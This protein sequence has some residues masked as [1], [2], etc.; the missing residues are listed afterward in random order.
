M[1]AIVAVLAVLFTCAI[2]YAGYRV[3]RKPRIIA[4]IKRVDSLHPVPRKLSNDERA[5]IERYFQVN[6]YLQ[7]TSPQATP[8]PESGSL[9]LTAQSDNIYAVTHA[10]TRYGLASDAPHKWRYFLDSTEVHLPPLWEQYIADDN[11]VEL[12]KTDSIPL[13]ISL[14]GH[15][16][17]DYLYAAPLVAPSA[18]QLM[19]N[20]SM[21]EQENEQV[22]LLDIR[23]ET[24]QE[25][26][27]N[28]TAGIRE[29]TLFSLVLILMFLSLLAPVSVVPWLAAAAVIFAVWGGWHLFRRPSERSRQ[30]IHCLRGTPKRWGLFGESD[31]GRMSSVSLGIIDLIYPPHWQPFIDADLGKKT[32]VDIYVNRQVVRQGRFLSLHN[33]MINFPVQRYLKNLILLCSSALVLCL[34]QAYVPLALPLKLSMAWLQGAQHVQAIDVDTMEKADLR[35]G[36]ALNA[37]GNGMCLVDSGPPNGPGTPF[38]PFDCSGIYWN[39]AAPLPLP[40]SD[41]VEKAEALL[42][43]AKLQLHP[44]QSTDGKINPGLASAIQKSGMTLLDNFSDIVLKTDAL[45]HDEGDCLRLK[46]ALVNLANGKNWPA[47][48]KRAHNGSL[49]GINVL[50]RPVSAANL[51]N[52]IANATSSFIVSETRSAINT[53]NSPSPGGFL[54]RSDEGNTLVNHPQPSGSLYDYS[55]IEQWRELQRRSS[56]L[57][58]TP[59]QAQGIITHLSTDAN[60]TR[61]I[62]LRSEPDMVT[63]WRFI[64]TSLLLLVVVVSIVVNGVLLIKRLRKS[65]HRTRDIQRYY[66]SCFNPHLPEA[67]LK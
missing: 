13:V 8:L 48:V 11:Y 35:I 32:D 49:R 43:T 37:K 5:A 25:H 60:G 42:T 34:L 45:C 20:S 12:I 57:L 36:D 62:S 54:I 10:I 6:K 4:S 53:L 23:K 59:F 63:I 26:A 56:M 47:I 52:L 66:E 7:Q 38:M 44:V 17:V 1:S 67:R 19:P 24:P 55:G 64:G 40:D 18:P 29:A 31:Q 50:L 21:R 28:R 39:K 33:E 22:E 41:T 46:S 27:V 58:H 16:L 14:N 2:G 15:S 65:R 9:A 51:E 3:Y 30:D 61:H